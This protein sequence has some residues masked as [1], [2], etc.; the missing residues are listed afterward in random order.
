[1][2]CIYCDGYVP[3]AE[4]T[5]QTFCTNCGKGYELFNRDEIWFETYWE[6][7]RPIKDTDD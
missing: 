7:Y 4:G 2:K 1:M 5:E 3:L 6:K